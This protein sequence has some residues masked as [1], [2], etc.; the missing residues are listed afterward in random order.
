[1][2]FGGI[3]YN[4]KTPLIAMEG[5]INAARYVDDCIDGTGLILDMN[6]IYGF[7]QWTLM[8]DGASIHTCSD[9]MIYLENMCNVLSNW[10]AN[11]PDLN[12][13]E[14]LWGIL[15]DR[16]QQVEPA[17]KDLLIQ[18]VFAAWEG[19]EQETIRKLVDSVPKRL[20]QVINENGGPSSY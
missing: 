2:F 5:N 10:P 12:P 19:I 15:K 7:W 20:R 3:A 17:D 4:Y 16:V 8:Q 1:M 14:N 13:I 6:K 11:S 9:T 18:T